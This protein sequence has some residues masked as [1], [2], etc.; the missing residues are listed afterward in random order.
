MT[1]WHW[2]VVMALVRYVLSRDNDWVDFR[3]EDQNVLFEALNK[4]DE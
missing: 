4:E 2:K 3:D 1:A